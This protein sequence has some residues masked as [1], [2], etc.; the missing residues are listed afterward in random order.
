MTNNE[1]YLVPAVEKSLLILE[2]VTN[3]QD[4]CSLREIYTDL[5]IAKTSAFSILNT[6]IYGGLI[7][8]DLKGRYIPTLKLTAMGLKARET[9]NEVQFVRPLLEKLR[10]STGF[11]VFYC[12]YDNGEQI[13]LHKLD[14]FSSIIFDSYIGQRKR[15]N[16]SANGKAMAAFLPR[17]ELELVLSKGLDK[18]TSKSICDESAFLSHLEEIRRQGYSVDDGEGELGIRCIGAPVFMYGGRLYGAVSI[19]TLNDNLPF[20]EIPA[21]AEQLLKTTSAISR[22]LGC[23]GEVT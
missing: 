18:L 1:A 8:K 13:V 7:R 4:G 2:H 9:T 22:D 20:S 10:D 11:T 5:G 14:G 15:M 23:E 6:L 19:S 12:I 16:T 21:Y 17:Q 3:A